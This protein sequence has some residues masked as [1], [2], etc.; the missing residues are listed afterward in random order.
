MNVTLKIDDNVLR[1]AR[2]RAIDQDLSLSAWTA[3]LIER[4]LG[5]SV[6]STPSS[7]L[8]RLG[9]ARLADRNFPLPSRSEPIQD[10]TW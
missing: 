2:H 5:L 7:L 9:D 4:E 3:K 8:D 10:V 6:H 1:Q